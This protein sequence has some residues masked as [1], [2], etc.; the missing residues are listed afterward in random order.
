[1]AESDSVQRIPGYCALCTSSCGC[2][3]VVEAGRLI[4]VEPDPSHP[5]GKALCG[6]GRAAP[7]LVHHEER[8]L[9]PLRRVSPKGDLDPQWERISWDEALDSTAEAL[10]RLAAS[11]PPCWVCSAKSAA[12]EFILAL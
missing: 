12:I 7:E 3:S 2:I 11:E 6:K 9:H 1:M 10:T 8:L 5:T 4:A